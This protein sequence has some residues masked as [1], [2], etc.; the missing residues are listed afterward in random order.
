VRVN[1]EIV[2]EET[3]TLDQPLEPNYAFGL[4]VFMDDYSTASVD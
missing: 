3:Q 2:V 1:G 4:Q